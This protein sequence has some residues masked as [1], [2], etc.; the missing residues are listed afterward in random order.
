MWSPLESEEG[1]GAGQLWIRGVN[2]GV[3]ENAGVGL[4]SGSAARS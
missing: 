2:G 4:M 1:Q 3:V